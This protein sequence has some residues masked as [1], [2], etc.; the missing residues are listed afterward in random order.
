M[1]GSR[2][3]AR[4][5]RLADSSAPPSFPRRRESRNQ[6]SPPRETKPELKPRHPFSL[7]GLTGVCLA[8]LGVDWTLFAISAYSRRH[9]RESGNPQTNQAI[10]SKSRLNRNQR[11]PSPF[12]GEG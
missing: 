1:A 3:D 8:D 6:P 12:M 9:S 11:I 5:L 4:Y 10:H 2:A 7:Y